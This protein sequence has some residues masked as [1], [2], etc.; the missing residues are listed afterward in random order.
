VLSTAAAGGAGHFAVQFAKLASCEVCD[1]CGSDKKA[2]GLEKLGCDHDVINYKTQEVNAAI[3][4]FAQNGL[5][6][7]LKVLEGNAAN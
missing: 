1:I 6:A 5:D 7:C 4:L 3:N 2:T